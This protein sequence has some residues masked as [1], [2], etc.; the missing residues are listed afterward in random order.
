[1]KIEESDKKRERVGGYFKR[2]IEKR[3]KERRG[4]VEN[5]IRKRKR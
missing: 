2:D 1:M 4:A 3:K 5:I